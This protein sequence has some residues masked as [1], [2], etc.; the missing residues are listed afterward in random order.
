MFDPARFFTHSLK[1]PRAARV[2]AAALDAAEPGGAVLRFLSSGWLPAHKRIFLLG[3]GKAAEPMTLA[4]AAFL[5]DY[6]GAL[7]ITKRATGEAPDHIRVIEAGHPVPDGRSL[8]AGAAALDF[9]SRLAGDDLLICLISGGGSALAVAPRPGA[10]LGRLQE[11]TN[12][13][14]ASG[15][16]IDEINRVRRGLDNLKGGGLAGA[17]RAQVLSLILSDVIGDPLEAIASGPTAP[18]PTAPED[19]LAVLE[20]Y[21]L[22]SDFR[23]LPYTKKEFDEG[24]FDRVRNVIVGNNRLA[25]EAAQR[26]AEIEGFRAE[27]ISTS[28]Q[29]EAAE[30]GAQLAER[31]GEESRAGGRPFCLIGGGETTVTLRGNG[32]GGR[33]QE[34]ALGAANPLAGLH[35]VMLISLATDGDDGPTDAAG[36]VVT[37]ESGRRAEI[38]GMKTA[39]Y[40]SRND[41]YPYFDRLGDL[42]KPGYTGTNVND[43]IFLFAF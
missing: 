28:I 34:L 23:G 13:L 36:A 15:A 11:L 14:L 27:I 30:I 29:G 16:S 2:L 38:L 25:A 35:D 40:L 3:L 7:V 8:H 42:L 17:T 26:Q 43:L 31:L 24:A 18:D 32:R 6:S 19:S 22:G 37:G 20:K 9:V 33:N 1:D 12:R 21:G 10:S 5:E 39:E 4:A 41:A